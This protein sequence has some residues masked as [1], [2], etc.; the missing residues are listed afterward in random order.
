VS[1]APTLFDIAPESPATVAG[2]SLGTELIG[3]TAYTSRRRSLAGRHPVDDT[4]V[5]TIIDTLA[6]RGGR[7]HR[8]TLAAQ[9]GI[10][11]YAIGGLLTSLRRV[12]N[13]DGYPV[14]DTD[15]DRVTAV[16][17]VALLR[18]QFGLGGS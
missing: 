4:V 15:P 8:D 5:V 13:V 10:A 9:L 14:L 7:A 3:S 12:L 18:E 2:A 11:A 6:A 17:D 1:E 16:L